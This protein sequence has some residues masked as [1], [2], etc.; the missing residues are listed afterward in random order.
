VVIGAATDLASALLADP[1]LA[2]R[3][4]IVAMAFRNWPDGG[5]EFNVKNDAKAW[6]VLLQ[7]TAPIVVADGAA[8]L[9]HLCMS[10]E[11]AQSLFGNRCDAGRYLSDLLSDWLDRRSDLVQT[12]TGGRTSWPVWDEGTVAYLLGMAK[13]EAHPR[14]QLRDD[15]KFEH[16]SADDSSGAIIQWI[17]SIDSDKLW[18]DFA[19]KLDQAQQQQTSK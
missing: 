13:T 8:A 6:Q 14:P 9:K 11:R 5:D 2:E 19:Q 7:S 16:P 18:E 1:S 4:Q 10:R 12:I 15:M 3:I 17:T